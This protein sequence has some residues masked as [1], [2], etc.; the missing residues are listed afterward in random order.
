MDSPR[1]ER[2]R[3]LGTYP[4]ITT[5]EPS[6]EADQTNFSTFSTIPAW[7]STTRTPN[8]ASADST[9]FS[10]PPSSMLRPERTPSRP[11]NL[12][13]AHVRPFRSRMVR[14]R[15]VRSR[16]MLSRCPWTATQPII[17]TGI[18]PQSQ[19]QG[20]HLIIRSPCQRT[21]T[22]SMEKRMRSATRHAR[23]A[24]VLRRKNPGRSGRFGEHDPAAP[25]S[26]FPVRLCGTIPCFPAAQYSRA[27]AGMK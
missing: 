27:P 17:A 23:A 13:V 11:V 10:G 7:L 14:T 15:S 26:H 21:R 1:A 24:T 4:S 16:S 5:R 20:L 9:A 6:R 12:T 19:R 8:V 18:R 2:A 22:A 3:S 25:E